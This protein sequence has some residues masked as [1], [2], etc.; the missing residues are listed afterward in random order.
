MGIVLRVW[1]TIFTNYSGTARLT[2]PVDMTTFLLQPIFLGWKK[3]EQSVILLF[4]FKDPFNACIE[5]YIFMVQGLSY[6]SIVHVLVQLHRLHMH[7]RIGLIGWLKSWI[8]NLEV[9]G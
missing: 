7:P 4:Y 2:N 8:W 5:H 1:E 6:K 3:N 9:P